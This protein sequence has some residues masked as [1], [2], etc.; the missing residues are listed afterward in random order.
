MKRYIF[1][2]ILLLILSSCK[3]GELIDFTSREWMWR[4]ADTLLNR[5]GDVK[6][7]Y[8]DSLLCK[9]IGKAGLD[10]SISSK[11]LSRIDMMLCISMHQSPGNYHP[12]FSILDTIRHDAYLNILM[13]CEEY[14]DS[15]R[16]DRYT[17]IKVVTI[18]GKY[19]NSC[20]TLAEDFTSTG[21]HTVTSS[22]M[23]PGNRVVTQSIQQLSSDIEDSKL[24]YRK[25][26]GIVSRNIT[27]ADYD[28]NSKGYVVK[29]NIYKRYDYD[30][31]TNRVTKHTET[32]IRDK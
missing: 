5:S 18:T 4:G 17:G 24:F 16:N 30:N 27:V 9:C 7:F 14:H 8:M 1:P 3:H 15:V 26:E 19:V 25:H 28:Y 29:S 6:V 20:Y 2:C 11:N 13:I 10:T 32:V 22:V 23:M 21:L 12:R 31:I